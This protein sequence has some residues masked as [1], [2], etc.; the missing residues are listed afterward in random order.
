M[1]AD[2]TSWHRIEEPDPGSLSVYT[3]S[4]GVVP[5]LTRN[6]FSFGAFLK[7]R[8]QLCQSLEPSFRV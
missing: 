5:V 7:L 3:F 6:V 4:G 2:T 1:S 8:S